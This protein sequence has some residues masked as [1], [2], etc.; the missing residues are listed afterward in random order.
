MR[1]IFSAPGMPVAWRLDLGLLLG[2]DSPVVAPVPSA[3]EHA[4]RWDWETREV[5]YPGLGLESC[6]A[7]LGAWDCRRRELGV[8]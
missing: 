5:R 6:P 3:D 1:D 2:P 7:G 8:S 4:R